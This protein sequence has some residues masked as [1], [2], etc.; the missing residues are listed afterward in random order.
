MSATIYQTE[1]MPGIGRG[2]AIVGTNVEKRGQFGDVDDYIAEYFTFLP[3][4]KPPRAARLTWSKSSASH[5]TPDMAGIRMMHRTAVEWAEID[6]NRSLAEA[7]DNSD[8]LSGIEAP[9]LAVA[10]NKVLNIY[11]ERGELSDILD[12]IKDKTELEAMSNTLE[13]FQDGDEVL[14]YKRLDPNT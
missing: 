7:V 10:E 5:V 11:A 14:S 2:F 3:G 8:L 6:L 13:R 1:R 12:W 4:R 9:T